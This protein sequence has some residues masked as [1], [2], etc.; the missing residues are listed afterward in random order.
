MS[1]PP[2][3]K[4]I[5]VTDPNRPIVLTDYLTDIEARLLIEDSE[6]PAFHGGIGGNSGWPNTGGYAQVIVRACD[7]DRARIAMARMQSEPDSEED[8]PGG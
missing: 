3:G 8:F 4:Q 2:K 5:M 7:L 1:G 6:I